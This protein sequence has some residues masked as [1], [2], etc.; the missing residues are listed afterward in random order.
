M[1]S[2]AERSGE[3]IAKLRSMT[4]YSDGEIFSLQM[5]SLELEIATQVMKV[6]WMKTI[7]LVHVI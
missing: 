6:S 7:C 4:Q 3:N 5:K 2:Y 1:T